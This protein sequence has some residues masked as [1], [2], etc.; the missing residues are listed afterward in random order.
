MRQGLAKVVAHLVK[1]LGCGPLERID[2]LLNIADDKN[3]ALFVRVRTDASGK[4]VGQLFDHGPL[5]RARVL[6][7]IDQHMINAAIKTEQHPLRDL[8]IRE[9][10]LGLADQVVEVEHAK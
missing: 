9:Q 1:R 10:C 7:L 3:R 6:G 5:V 2:R 4:F 8:F